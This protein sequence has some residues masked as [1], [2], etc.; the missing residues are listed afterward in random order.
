MISTAAL[1]FFLGMALHQRWEWLPLI[2]P[3]ALLIWIALVVPTP[4]P[5]IETAKKMLK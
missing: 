5:R 1:M 4:A 3:G 2:V